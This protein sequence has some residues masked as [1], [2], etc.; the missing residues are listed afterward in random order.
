[1]SCLRCHVAG[2]VQ[3]VWYR[4][5][6]RERAVQLGLDGYARNLTD[7]RVEVLA[8]GEPAALQALREWLWQGSPA[9]EVDAVEC[10]EVEEAVPAGFSTA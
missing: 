7:G 1:M 3:G 10:S 2:R 5:S 9:A 8:C 4:A 6:T